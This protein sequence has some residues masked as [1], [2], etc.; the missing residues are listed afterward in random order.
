MNSN[1]ASPLVLAVGA[2]FLLTWY[3]VRRLRGGSIRLE[4]P[5][6]SRHPGGPDDF[7]ERALTALRAEFRDR[8]EARARFLAAGGAVECEACG[9]V[10]PAG[11]L[12]CD[13]GGET[14]E[15]EEE[16]E[17]PVPAGEAGEADGE[18]PRPASAGSDEEEHGGDLVVVHIAENHWKG[19]LLRSYLESNG[20]PCITGGNVPSIVYQF[21]FTPLG[22]VRLYVHRAHADE[23]RE[24]LEKT[25]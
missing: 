16:D 7:R 19:S 24:L 23:A 22:E 8:E 5:P 13:C 25:R 20:I 15:S 9:A 10:H 21:N 17:Q 14:C 1:Q 18:E 4:P 11:T 12:Y 6:S 2:V 3:G